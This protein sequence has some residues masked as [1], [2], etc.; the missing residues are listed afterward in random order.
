MEKQH[1]Q[2]MFPFQKAPRPTSFQCGRKRCSKCRA[3]SSFPARQICQSPLPSTPTGLTIISTP[4]SPDKGPAGA[5]ELRSPRP[6]PAGRCTAPVV[7]RPRAP[8][9]APAAPRRAGNVCP[10]PRVLF[11]TH[12]RFSVHFYKAGLAQALMCSYLCFKHLPEGRG[13]H[14]VLGWSF[15]Q[16]KAKRRSSAQFLSHAQL[17][18]LCFLL[19]EE[20]RT[21]ILAAGNC[22]RHTW[23]LG[24]EQAV[25]FRT[26]ELEFSLCN[27]GQLG[28]K[29]DG[30]QKCRQALQKRGRNL[31]MSLRPPHLCADMTAVP[32]APRGGCKEESQL[33]KK[34]FY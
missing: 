2:H 33:K 6:G 8:S 11:F 7:T 24:P 32:R 13:S 21:L 25:K 27:R 14:K 28:R 34:L 22:Y 18:E 19:G 20:G 10:Q 3:Y 29:N 26:T 23:S 16:R 15:V 5:K 9:P 12:L 31:S 1:C 30:R 17:F 4:V